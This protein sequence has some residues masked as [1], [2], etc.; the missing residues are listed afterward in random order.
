MASPW[1]EGG[2]QFSP[3]QIQGRKVL[4]RPLLNQSGFLRIGILTGEL[5]F[6]ASHVRI[7]EN[8]AKTNI[9]LDLSP[10]SLPWLNHSRIVASA[11]GDKVQTNGLH[12]RC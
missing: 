4:I 1:A 7:R 12:L 2:V 6:P 5:L 3:V 9:L 11:D 10:D 8:Y